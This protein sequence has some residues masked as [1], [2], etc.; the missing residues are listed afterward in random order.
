MD[1]GILSD[2]VDDKIGLYSIND[3]KIYG[4]YIDNLDKYIE[5]NFFLLV[6]HIYHTGSIPSKINVDFNQIE[7]IFKYFNIDMSPEDQEFINNYE[8]ISSA[9]E[10]FEILMNGKIYYLD[11]RYQAFRDIISNISCDQ[12]RTNFEKVYSNYQKLLVEQQN[13]FETVEVLYYYEDIK[14]FNCYN[15]PDGLSITQILLD[16]EI[17]DFLPKEFEDFYYKA[18]FLT[19]E[20]Q[21]IKDI[22]HQFPKYETIISS[23]ISCRNYKIIDFNSICPEDFNFII[24]Y[25]DLEDYYNEYIIDLIQKN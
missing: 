13:K 2:I 4:F 9:N 18:K 23:I 7:Y 5:T 21:D 1:Y 20:L 22:L 17:I 19:L 12:F 11:P 3:L 10:P 24:E 14:L 8:L 25:C 6:K 16:E 15:Y